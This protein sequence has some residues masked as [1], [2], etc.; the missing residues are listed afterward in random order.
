[1]PWATRNCMGAIRVEIL[2]C[3]KDNMKIPELKKRA[4]L[5][6]DIDEL[7]EERPNSTVNALELCLSSTEPSIYHECNFHLR[8]GSIYSVA[9][10][11]ARQYNTPR[12][13]WGLEGTLCPIRCAHVWFSC[14]LF[15]CYCVNWWFKERLQYLQ[16]ISNGDTTVLH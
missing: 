10:L 11:L 1:M 13:C 7:V 3:L 2:S 4:H 9:W 16:C 12:Y 14:A 8:E 6:L 15:W 5:G